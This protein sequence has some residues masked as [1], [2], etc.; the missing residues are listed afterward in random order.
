MTTRQPLLARRAGFLRDLSSVALRALRLT[1]RDAE[2]V[3]PG[4]VVPPV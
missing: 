3:V 2:A 1:R 4:L